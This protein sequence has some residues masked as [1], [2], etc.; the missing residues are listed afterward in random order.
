MLKVPK[1]TKVYLCLEITDMRR[2]YDRLTQMVKE[3]L[4]QDPTSG[5]IFIFRNK[6]ADK[7]KLLYWDKNGYVI[8]YKRFRKGSFVMPPGLKN[9]FQMTHEMFD[10]L[11]E[12]FHPHLERRRR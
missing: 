11:L 9:D 4:G 6:A 10:K 12:G 3:F 5:H 2:S 1:G 7:L 8:W